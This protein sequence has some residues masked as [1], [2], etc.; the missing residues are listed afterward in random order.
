MK[1]HVLIILILSTVFAIHSDAQYYHYGRPRYRTRL[2]VAPAPRRPQPPRQAQQKRATFEP[3]LNLSVGYG[4]PNL[5]K[6]Q[7]VNFIDAYK[8]NISQTGPIT[9][10][11]DYQFSPNMSIGVV[12]TY[13]KVSAPYY[14]NY[15]SGS[16]TADFTGK[17]ENWSVMLNLMTYFPTYNKTVEPY[18]R[19]AIGINNWKQDYVDQNN[20]KVYDF[21]KPSQL[22][23]QASLGARFNIT[24]NAGLYIEG[25]YGKYIINGGLTLKF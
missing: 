23:Y 20:T 6:E 1:K 17:L 2:R 18:L 15:N 5:D 13:G 11:L 3:T 8:G 9:G 24:K 14:N 16:N 19:T 10:A 25:G 7:L 4:F 21:E 22:A 12:G